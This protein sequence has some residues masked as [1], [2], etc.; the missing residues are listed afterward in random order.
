ML[1]FLYEK[2]LMFRPQALTNV[3]IHQSYGM[4]NY[5]ALGLG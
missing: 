4:Y 2:T 5:A 3:Y 1:P